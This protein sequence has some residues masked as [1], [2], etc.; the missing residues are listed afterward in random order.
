MNRI[1]YHEAELLYGGS[2]VLDPDEPIKTTGYFL[3]V[4][5]TIRRQLIQKR[6]MPIS[7]AIEF[8]LPI[9]F[10]GALALGML[11]ST[12]T[13]YPTTQY[14]TKGGTPY[15]PGLL[16]RSSVCYK[17][18]DVPLSLASLILPC[19]PVHVTCAEPGRLPVDN[20]CVYGGYTTAAVFIEMLSSFENEVQLL[21]FDEMVLLQ[22]IIRIFGDN[23]KLFG[24]RVL[25]ALTCSGKIYLIPNNNKTS[26]L[27]KYLSETF[28]TFDHV[29]GGFAQS[30]EEILPSILSVKEGGNTWALIEIHEGSPGKPKFNIELSLNRTAVPWPI[31]IRHLLSKGVHYKDYAQYYASGF[32]TLQKTLNEYYLTHVLPSE[33]FV[34]P[35]GAVPMIGDVGIVPMGFQKFSSNQFFKIAGPVAPLV[36]V[37]SFLYMV[38]QLSKRL[39]EEKELR[40]REGTMVMGLTRSAFFSSWLLVY[41][42]QTI[43]SCTLVSIFIKLILLKKSDFTIIWICYCIFGLCAVNTS[44]LLST[45]FNKARIAALI[46]P[47]VYLLMSLPAFAIK[48]DKK[49][50]LFL[51]SFLPPIPFSTANKLL[52]QY[53]INDGMGWD[54]AASQNDEP[55]NY[56]FCMGILIFD[57]FLT[58]VLTL[59]LDAVLPKEWG[60]RKSICFCFTCKCDEKY[61]H[62]RNHDKGNRPYVKNHCDLQI[63]E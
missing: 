9:L 8:L 18:V 17:D 21:N 16:I 60:T 19:A 55:Y 37:M 15:N 48:S 33:V 30:R 61:H 39:V 24:Y 7:W 38:S 63:I 1:N 42:I 2:T 22:W 14:I 58:L 4:W 34:S 46:V 36:I 6:R 32:L 47:L 35:T 59:Y 10:I 53:E 13:Y 29:F 25:D 50:L 3:Q 28:A 51:L 43:L 31:Y 40:L 41:Y 45:F 5:C 27:K 20:I 11:V 49:L 54:T 57:F 26:Q 62:T 23:V 52:F 56:M 12:S 44:A